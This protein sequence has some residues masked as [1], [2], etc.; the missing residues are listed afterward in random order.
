MLRNFRTAIKSNRTPVATIMI[1]LTIGL[2]AYLV[3]SGNVVVTPETVLGRVYGR[4]IKQRDIDQALMDLMQRFGGAQAQQEQLL[5]LL[6]PQ[7]VQTAIQDKI[8]EELCEREGIVVSDAEIKTT[9]ELILKS[10]AKQQPELI[11]L[12]DGSGR[13]RSMDELVKIYQ[14]PVRAFINT[15]ERVARKEAVRQK[16]FQIY[17]YK[18]PVSLERLD[19]E[20]RLKEEKMTFKSVV[21]T[22][23]MQDIGDPGDG[24]LE[25]F[26]KAEGSLFKQGLR[27]KIQVVAVS[28][29]M[30]GDLNMDEA[31]VRK[32][33]EN[34]KASLAKAPEVKGRHIL[35]D[36]TTPQQLV[37][38]KKVALEVREQLIKGEKFETLATKYN[39]PQAAGPGG[40]LGWFD[41]SRMVKEFGDAAFS[42][43]VGEISQPVQTQ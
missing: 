42:L 14:E 41:R 39:S 27:R 11:G 23:S 5:P 15:V 10:Q 13:L 9:L 35:F 18:V 28:R 30:V 29:D 3:P 1:V 32:A 22:P 2:L 38:A 25:V 6:K 12:F 4:E 37:E 40:D 36:A 26:L 31:A 17:A 7:A 16:L 34:Q 20:H 33:Y 21:V 43:K 8:V 19:L 24:P